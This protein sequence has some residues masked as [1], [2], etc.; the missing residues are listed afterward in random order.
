MQIT[1]QMKIVIKNRNLYF[2]IKLIKTL[3]KLY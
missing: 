3:N 1:M 2:M